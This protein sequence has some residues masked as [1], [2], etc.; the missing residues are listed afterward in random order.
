MSIV[1]NRKSLFKRLYEIG[2]R[3]QSYDSNC[4]NCFRY[5]FLNEFKR[6]PTKCDWEDWFNRH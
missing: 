4:F 1:K 6:F 5:K 2:P 3:C